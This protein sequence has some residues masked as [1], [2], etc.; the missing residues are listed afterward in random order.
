MS[1]V[2]YHLL[3]ILICLVKSGISQDLGK[4][5]ELGFLKQNLNKF[6]APLLRIELEF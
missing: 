5:Y 4:N 1:C 3:L 6:W 2:E